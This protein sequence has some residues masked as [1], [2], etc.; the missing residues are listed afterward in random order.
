MIKTEPPR[1]CWKLAP[2]HRKQI[3]I[4]GAKW[5][6]HWISASFQNCKCYSR[7]SIQFL[8]TPKWPQDF[9]TNCW[10]KYCCVLRSLSQTPR[11]T[12]Q[13]RYS[14]GSETRGPFEIPGFQKLHLQSRAVP[15]FAT[16][17]AHEIYQSFSEAEWATG[18]HQT[19]RKTQ[20]REGARERAWRY[21]QVG[22][23][24][25]PGSLPTGPAHWHEL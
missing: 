6:N 17:K 22:T 3:K 5:L 19:L 12:H 2:S 8:L 1:N 18:P 4:F 20:V 10:S 14:P 21:F 25:D 23:G 16:Q 7:S 24:A 11:A 13:R 9:T 15:H